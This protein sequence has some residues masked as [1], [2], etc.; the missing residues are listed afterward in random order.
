MN[1]VTN[2]TISIHLYGNYSNQICVEKY[3]VFKSSYK[4]TQS[5]MFRYKIYNM[6][7]WLILQVLR[8]LSVKVEEGQTVA[9][10]GSSGCG[11]STI[12]QLMMRFY[13]TQQGE[14]SIHNVHVSY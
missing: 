10:V 5:V 12:I 9:L 6:M 3:S 7:H 4:I 8:G 14:V 1:T 13:E 2:T 11:K